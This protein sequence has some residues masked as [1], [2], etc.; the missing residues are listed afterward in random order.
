MKKELCPYC[1]KYCDTKKEF[2][3][4]EYIVKG[5]KISISVSLTICKICGENI[6]SDEEDQ[7]ILDLIHKKY[8][9]KFGENKK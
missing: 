6:G 5:E 9:K 8:N 2:R 4:E 1:E 3:E 7:R